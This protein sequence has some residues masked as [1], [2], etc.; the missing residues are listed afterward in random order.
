MAQTSEIF[1]GKSR[2]NVTLILQ[3]L[4]L[5]PKKEEESQRNVI[6]KTTC[7]I[8]GKVCDVIIDSGSSE[9]IVSEA[10]VKALKH[11]VEPH[12]TPYKIT[13]VMKGVETIVKETNTF[14]FSIGKSY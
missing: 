13:W 4:L 2:L 12:A 10:L 5:A 6:F 3:K 11:K 9:N 1:N 14:V 8:N 7:T